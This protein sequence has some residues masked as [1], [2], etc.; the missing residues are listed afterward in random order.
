MDAVT[1]AGEELCDLQPP[2]HT[3]KRRPY[4]ASS[5]YRGLPTLFFPYSMASVGQELMQAMQ[6]V[7]FPPQTG[8]PL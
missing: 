8:L 5:R 6:W 7:Q 2:G 1:P 3:A 4:S